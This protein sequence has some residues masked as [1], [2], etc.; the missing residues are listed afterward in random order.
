VTTGRFAPSPTADLHIG[1]LRTALLAWLFAR[2][3]P[4]AGPGQRGGFIMRVEDLDPAA[5]RSDIAERQLA[6]VA[7]LGVDWDGGVVRQSDRFDLYHRAI[8]QLTAAGLT[9]PCWC[10]RRE[11]AEA[12]TAP[13]HPD[14]P[15]GAYPGT[16]A[17]L[18]D[19]ARARRAAAS[20]RQPALRL[21]ASGARV[22]VHDR[23]CGPVDGMV[24]DF[25]IRRADGVPAYNLAV[26]VDDA[27][28]GVD[29]VVRGDDL[30]PS[31]PRQVLLHHL[32]GL[33]VP[34]YAHVPLVLSP[35]GGR[36]AKRGAGTTLGELAD[37][38]WSATDVVTLMAVSLGM[39][40]PGDTVTAD[41]LVDRFDPDAL[42]RQPWYFTPDPGGPAAIR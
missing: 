33:A 7:A 40:A 11:V 37:A 34:Q 21:R 13:N 30:L 20:D 39:A 6:D 10:S 22:S 28:Q 29:Q 19:D 16:C 5:R 41:M 14:M 9:Y 4:G 36:M 1:N 26:V 18:D 2:S 27:D 25:V 32:L 31:T 12:A 3:A 38:G 8:D 24:D 15:E 17:P 35:G 23:V 42:P